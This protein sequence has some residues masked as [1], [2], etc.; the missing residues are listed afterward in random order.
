[1]LAAMS[2]LQYM[3]C[4]STLTEFTSFPEATEARE[5]LWSIPIIQIIQIEIYC[6]VYIFGPSFWSV[7]SVLYHLP[8]H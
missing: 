5:L 1:M 8:I 3:G 4:L 2:T 6:E 7:G